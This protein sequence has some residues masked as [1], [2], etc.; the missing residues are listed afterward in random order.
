MRLLE[1]DGIWDLSMCQLIS[2]HPRSPIH[3]SQTVRATVFIVGI[4]ILQIMDIKLTEWLWPW[5]LPCK[6]WHHPRP[7]CCYVLCKATHFSARVL[8][9]SK[10]IISLVSLVHNSAWEIQKQWETHKICYF[11]AK[12]SNSIAM[13]WCI[14]S[15][16]NQIVSIQS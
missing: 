16:T 7:R 4:Q 8:Q 13:I 12:L 6:V 5:P 2:I 9:L 3:H 10:N 11:F 1:H 15:G 14:K